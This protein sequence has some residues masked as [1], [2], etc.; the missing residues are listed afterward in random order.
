MTGGGAYKYQDRIKEKL[1]LDIGKCDEMSCIVQVDTIRVS[2]IS[3]L[4][5]F[6]S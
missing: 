3:Y 5:K 2:M 6:Y 4:T 1:G